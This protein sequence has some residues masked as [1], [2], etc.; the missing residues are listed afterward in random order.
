VPIART[1]GNCLSM[2]VFSLLT[3]HLG[4]ARALDLLLRARQLTGAEARAAGFV[5]ELVADA[6]G[7]DAALAETVETL[8]AHAPLT[9]WAAKRAA[10][11]L[12]RATLPGGDDLVERVYGS[13]DF[14]AA[15]AA[16]GSGRRPE[17]T[18]S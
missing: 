6:A 4:P 9:M 16:F 15:V 3:A 17:W 2:D 14:A 7:L 1:L 13:A 5:A 12:R 8:V 10:V 11:R 18:G